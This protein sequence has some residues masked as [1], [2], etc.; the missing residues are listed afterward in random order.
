[1]TRPTN[2]TTTVTVCLLARDEREHA[3]I[4]SAL[5]V[6]GIACFYAVDAESALNVMRTNKCNGFVASVSSI[7]RIGDKYRSDIDHVTG[8][9]PVLLAQSDHEKSHVS[10]TYWCKA[11]TD[12]ESPI[13]VFLSDCSVISPRQLRNGMRTKIPMNV[14]VSKGEVRERGTLVDISPSGMFVH[15][16]GDWGEGEKATVEIR[17]AGDMNIEGVIQHRV[18]WGERFRLSGIGF[19][20]LNPPENMAGCINTLFREYN[21]VRTEL[22][23]AR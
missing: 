10:F 5:L 23:F 22:N 14:I 9:F 3:Q 16:N 7:A 2:S 17:E 4:A 12:C 11:T 19:R 8:S 13:S 20:F 6:H 18:P 21:H 1:M 15:L